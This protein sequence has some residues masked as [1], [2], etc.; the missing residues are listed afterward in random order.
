MPALLVGDNRA[1]TRGRLVAALNCLR[2]GSIESDNDTTGDLADAGA[3]A[4]SAASPTKN[5]E[6]RKV[7]FILS[8]TTWE[9]IGVGTTSRQT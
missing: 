1:I 5:S 6:C 9:S 7:R 4:A 3:A 8:L 2:S